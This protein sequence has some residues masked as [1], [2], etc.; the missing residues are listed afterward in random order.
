[1]SFCQPDFSKNFQIGGNGYLLLLSSPSQVLNIK[2]SFH[3]KDSKQQV[4]PMWNKQLVQLFS[5]VDPKFP[6]FSLSPTSPSPLHVPL[7]LFGN[8]SASPVS[9]SLQ[10]FISDT[11]TA[12]R[13]SCHGSSSWASLS[14]WASWSKYLFDSIRFNRLG[15][16]TSILSALL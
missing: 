4:L 6:Y 13:G 5:H 3:Q 7:F 9:L 14:S 15:S 1:M 10:L 16:V 12:S 2:L 8:C 11:G